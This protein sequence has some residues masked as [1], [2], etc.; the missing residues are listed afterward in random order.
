MTNL[1]NFGII[2]A[3]SLVILG[4][5]AIIACGYVAETVCAIF[6]ERGDELDD[7]ESFV[8]GAAE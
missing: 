5:I 8:D 6:A 7:L 3:V 4:I 2:F 1:R